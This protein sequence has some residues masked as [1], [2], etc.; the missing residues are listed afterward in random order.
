MCAKTRQI[1]NLAAKLSCWRL[2]NV[3][4][5]YLQRCSLKAQEMRVNGYTGLISV[6]LKK[7]HKLD[8]IPSLCPLLMVWLFKSRRREGW[9]TVNRPEVKQE[10]D[11]NQ[12]K[13]T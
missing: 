2:A 12:T 13:V 8:E 5:K 1:R 11:R 9:K 10:F 7:F 4:G 3:R 6:R